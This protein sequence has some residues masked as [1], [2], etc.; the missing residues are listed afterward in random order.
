MKESRKFSFG[1]NW[2]RYIKSIDKVTVEQAKQSLTSLFNQDNGLIEGKT[3]LDIGCGSGLFCLAAN[4]LGA[5]QVIGIDIDIHSIEASQT[6]A[7]RF[8]VN[9]MQFLQGSVLNTE[10]IKKLNPADIVYAW[11]SL[12]HTGN[13]WVA[14]ENASSL[15]KHG[16]LF[17]IAIYNKHK[18]SPFWK[19]VKRIYNDV[20]SFLKGFLIII[21]ILVNLP[22]KLLVLRTGLGDEGNRGMKFYT[23]AIDWLGG[24]PYEYASIEELNTFV[25]KKGFKLSKIIPCHG[26]TGCNQIV[27]QR[28]P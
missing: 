21:Y 17:I 24:W 18:T 9:G 3:F 15:V 7:N 1:K 11:G 5:K 8:N 20:P 14:I 27:Y 26:M 6:L 13:M 19:N 10:F 16:G 2:K 25:A 23:D 12:H 22:Y 4:L 28:Y